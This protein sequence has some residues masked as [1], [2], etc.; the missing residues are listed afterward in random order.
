M[1]LS[2]LS[3]ARSLAEGCRM[4][5]TQA[6]AAF[7]RAQTTHTLA[8]GAARDERLSKTHGAWGGQPRRT[9]SMPPLPPTVLEIEAEEAKRK[10]EMAE[11][12]FTSAQVALAS[13]ESQ[14]L[15]IENSIL[16]GHRNTLAVKIRAAMSNGDPAADGLLE[17]L[18]VL[19][20]PDSCIRLHQRFRLSF[21]V[22]ELLDAQQQV[23]LIDTPI[24]I[25]RGEG[26]HDYETRRAQILDESEAAYSA[27]H[28]E[29]A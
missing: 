6:K 22:K 13:A 18:K 9:A 15:E 1:T 29:V 5:F 12:A 25:L 11:H 21:A 24:N 16:N 17:E 26:H 3:N 7:H 10:F 2:P 20:P 8:A 14:L 19:C 27:T 4:A 28:Q 23:M